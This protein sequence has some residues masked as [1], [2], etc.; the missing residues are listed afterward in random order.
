MSFINILRAR[1][2]PALDKEKEDIKNKVINSKEEKAKKKEKEKRKKKEEK[3]KKKEK[4]ER[5]KK[6]E[7]ER[8]REEEKKGKETGGFNTL[9]YKVASD[10]FKLRFYT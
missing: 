8:K 2:I 10:E 5:K 6:E 3:R 9:N 1:S 7:K 4:K